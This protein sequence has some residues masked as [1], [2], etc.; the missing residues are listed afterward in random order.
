MF[1]DAKGVMTPLEVKVPVQQPTP[2]AGM[3]HGGAHKH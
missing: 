1:K 2:P 3:Q